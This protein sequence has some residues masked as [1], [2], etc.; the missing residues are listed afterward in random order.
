MLLHEGYNFKKIHRDKREFYRR[1]M[2]KPRSFFVQ[3]ASDNQLTTG[4]N[5]IF[6]IYSF[7]I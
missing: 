4:V 7:I 6:Y 3:D 5:N 1:I 2:A